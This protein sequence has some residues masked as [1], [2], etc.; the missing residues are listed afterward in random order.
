MPHL[1]RAPVRLSHDETTSFF[2]RLA[3]LTMLLAVA[4]A[5]ILDA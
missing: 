4:A 1:W 3:V 2:V 5:M